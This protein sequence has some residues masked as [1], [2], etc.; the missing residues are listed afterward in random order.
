MGY[1][2]HVLLLRWQSLLLMLP[3]ER[4]IIS[5]CGLR[6]R[7]IMLLLLLLQRLLLMSC[8]SDHLLLWTAAIACPVA[9][10]ERR[11]NPLLLLLWWQCL[12]LM[13]LWEGRSPAVGACGCMSCCCSCGGTSI[14][15][16]T[17]FGVHLT[18]VL[19]F[20]MLVPESIQAGD[21]GQQ[22][23]NSG[24]FPS[25]LYIQGHEHDLLLVQEILDQF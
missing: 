22:L 6:R 2:R 24:L 12:L 16:S 23:N 9:A 17:V 7:H 19:T 4:S 8:G 20:C 1:W 11:R 18:L 3:W 15:C 13:L 14:C 21:L 25:M 10:A 5:C